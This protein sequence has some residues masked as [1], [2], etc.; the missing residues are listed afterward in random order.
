MYKILGHWYFDFLFQFCLY[1]CF[2]RLC[3]LR[4]L[5]VIFAAVSR[6]YQVSRGGV[7]IIILVSIVVVVV[8]IVPVISFS[9]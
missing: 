8:I 4:W 1:L 9:G 6:F 7:S 3:R 5:V 2:L